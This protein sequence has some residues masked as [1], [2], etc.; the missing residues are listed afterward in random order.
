MNEQT[1]DVFLTCDTL[2]ESQSEF[3]WRI[4]ND[5]VKMNC[6]LH[7]AFIVIDFMYVYDLLRFICLFP[8]LFRTQ[9]LKALCVFSYFSSLFCNSLNQL[10]WNLIAFH[11]DDVQG[12]CLFAVIHEYLLHLQLFHLFF[13]IQN[14]ETTQKTTH[15]WVQWYRYRYSVQ[16][17]TETQQQI[18]TKDNEQQWIQ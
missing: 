1:D 18:N 2:Q 8:S 15:T 6:I 10:L 7:V 11:T 14:T 4:F 3:N 17:H 16:T 9:V 5:T 12:K 13:F